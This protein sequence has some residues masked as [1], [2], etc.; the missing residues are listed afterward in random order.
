MLQEPVAID[1]VVESESVVPLPFAPPASP[2]SPPASPPPSTPP[3]LEEVVRLE[4]ACTDVVARRILQS[5]TQ[6][7]EES[8]AAYLTATLPANIPDRDIVVT[9]V[10]DGRGRRLQST[11]EASSG[12]ED[13]CDFTYVCE[14][15]V[16]GNVSA[17][18]LVNITNS[19]KFEKDLDEFIAVRGCCWLRALCERLL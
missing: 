11:A 14:I 16:R 19:T 1:G 15:F 13:P 10:R 7:S 12:D 8:L 18:E 6:L 4:V 17:A 2:P 5:G 3:P 9:A